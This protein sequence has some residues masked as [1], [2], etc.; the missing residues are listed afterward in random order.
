MTSVV[1]MAAYLKRD[2]EDSARDLGGDLIAIRDHLL[3]LCHIADC[4]NGES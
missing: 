1:K 3:A 2:A 4:G